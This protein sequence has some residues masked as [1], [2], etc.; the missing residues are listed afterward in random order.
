MAEYRR[1]SVPRMVEKR[2]T[3]TIN[4]PE[5]IAKVQSREI[6]ST[7]HSWPLIATRSKVENERRRWVMSSVIIGPV[8][9]FLKNEVLGPRGTAHICSEILNPLKSKTVLAGI[10][11]AIILPAP[12]PPNRRQQQWTANSAGV[13]SKVPPPE[14]APV[15]PTTDQFGALLYA[16]R[17]KGGNAVFA[18]YIQF[19][20]GDL[21]REA[22]HVVWANINVGKIPEGPVSTM[23]TMR[24][25]PHGQKKNRHRSTGTRGVEGATKGYKNA[26]YKGSARRAGVPKNGAPRRRSSRIAALFGR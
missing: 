23:G 22:Y 15:H 20:Y 1:R 2:L 26:T 9:Q 24:I 13:L 11:R 18:K 4:S 17:E 19:L 7:Q 6:P 5:Y 25:S 16:C 12:T 3:A 8:A 21:I 10:A 14:A